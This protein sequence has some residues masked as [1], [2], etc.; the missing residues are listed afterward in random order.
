ML[1]LWDKYV[2]LAG[3]PLISQLSQTTSDLWLLF[4]MCMKETHILCLDVSQIHL[5]KFSYSTLYQAA[6]YS[7]AERRCGSVQSLLATL[8]VLVAQNDL[9]LKPAER[10]PLQRNSKDPY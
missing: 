1:M 8:E 9:L 3:T 2:D 4:L 10:T 5:S 7:D 6:L